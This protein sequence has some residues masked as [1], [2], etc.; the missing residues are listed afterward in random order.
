M[1]SGDA[2]FN[3]LSMRQGFFGGAQEPM[4]RMDFNFGDAGLGG[5]FGHPLAPMIMQPLINS[6]FGH[7]GMMPAQ[8]SPQ[9]SFYDQQRAKSYMQARQAAMSTASQA[10]RETYVGMLRG[11]AQA[12]GTPWGLEQQRSANVMAGDL[13]YMAPMLAQAMPETFDA[14]HGT[15]GSATV[16]ASFLH[17]GGLTAVDSATGRTGVSGAS[18]G[19]LAAE[20]HRRFF[21]A[22]ADLA[23]WRGLSAGRAGA[24]YDELQTRGLMGMSIG[25]R[26]GDEQLASL[27]SSVTSRQDAVQL[28]RAQD[29]AKYATLGTGPGGAGGAD[30]TD[31][32]KNLKDTNSTQYDALL[33]QFDAN[34]IGNRLKSMSGAVAAMREI[35]GDMGHPNAPMSQLI[36]GLNKLTQGGLATMSPGQLEQTV[37]TTQV[38]ARTSGMGMQAFQALASQGAAEAQQMGLDPRFG[39]TSAQSAAE[40]GAAFGQVGRGDVAAWGRVDREKLTVM[41]AQL[42]RQAAASPMANRLGAIMRIYETMG[43]EA[44]AGTPLAAVAEAIKRGDNEFEYKGKTESLNFDEARYRQITGASHVTGAAANDYLRSNAATQEQ[45]D[46]YGIADITR[47]AQPA[48]ARQMMVQ[49]FRE[50]VVGQLSASG[51]TGDRARNITTVASAAQ[52]QALSTMPVDVR[53]NDAARN[54]YLV[55]ATRAALKSQL[56]MSD[57]EI[58]TAFP[59]AQ[60]ATMVAGGVGRIQE[61]IRTD[62]RYQDYQSL[63]GYLDSQSEAVE[64]RRRDHRSGEPGRGG[65]R[66]GAGRTEHSRAAGPDHGS[67]PEPER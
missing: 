21:G 12:Q 37:R 5:P 24:L 2:F 9:Q 65:R 35:F 63:H 28:L 36:E 3:N 50:S 4:Q 13:A 48:E 53:S 33:R 6:M 26:T 18:A 44:L 64:A 25:A 55:D 32:I 10:D 39:L 54:Q 7:G 8:F 30:V 27:T 66:Q 11:M 52:A 34:Q 14:L 51:V 40:F 46:R 22:D 38:I 45:I 19:V 1:S 49:H 56:G 57:A 58:E 43:P 23:G 31:A 15:R 59:K 61:R 60:F 67:D 42:R 17:R 20:M 47:R 62:I 41:D 29:P 16:M